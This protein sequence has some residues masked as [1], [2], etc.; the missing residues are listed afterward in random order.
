MSSRAAQF[1]RLL[2]RTV[3]EQLRARYTAASTGRRWRRPAVDC[4]PWC[5]AARCTAAQRRPGAEHRSDPQT[6][7]TPYG[8]LIISLIQTV[9]G[10]TSLELRADIR[11]DDQAGTARA[12]A[13]HLTVGVDLTVRAVLADIA[14]QTAAAQL[15]TRTPDALDAWLAGITREV[16]SG[17][18]PDRRAVRWPSSGL[19]RGHRRLELGRGRRLDFPAD[20]H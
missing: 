10:R 4:P 18:T 3:G 14:Q 6:W 9:N 16:T 15:S 1:A 12:Q 19:Q 7:H 13:Q 11:L 8:F 2:A 17:G 5:A 20:P